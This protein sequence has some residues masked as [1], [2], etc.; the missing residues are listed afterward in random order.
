MPL[1]GASLYLTCI[2]LP[3]TSLTSPWAS[4]IA[5]DCHGPGATIWAYAIA[6]AVTIT[7]PTRL[8]SIPGLICDPPCRARRSEFDL[9]AALVGLPMGVCERNH[10]LTGLRHLQGKS[11]KRVL[12]HRLRSL[13]LENLF[14][15]IRD[16]NL[17]HELIVLRYGLLV[18]VKR[19]DLHGMGDKRPDP[20]Y[21]ALGNRGGQT[22]PDPADIG[23]DLGH[24]HPPF[25]QQHF[26]VTPRSHLP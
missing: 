16:D 23:A 10:E 9:R 13:G 25:M 2:F 21:L 18:L 11:D 6:R 20:Y 22:N 1:N 17:V 15:V 12:A 19:Q 24:G 4:G 8:K 5:R 14:P 3:S 7:L 26:L